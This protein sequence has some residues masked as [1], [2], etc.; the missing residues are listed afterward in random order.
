[1]AV[2]VVLDVEKCAFQDIGTLKLVF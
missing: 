2:V 1:M